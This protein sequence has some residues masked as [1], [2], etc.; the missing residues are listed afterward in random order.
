M[1]FPRANTP[2]C[3]ILLTKRLAKVQERLWP[4]AAM[5]RTKKTRTV[6]P[7]PL[8]NDWANF[9]ADGRILSGDQ[10]LKLGI[11]GRDWRFS[12]MPL[13]APRKLPASKMKAPILVEYHVRPTISRI[14]CTCF[15]QS[16]L[17][18]RFPLKLDA[19]PRHA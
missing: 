8:A 15:G 6:A 16:E 9:Y 19:G 4:R 10:A 13:T 11:G 17:R 2:W 7:A 18:P 5:P 3:R 1:K 12:G 14:S